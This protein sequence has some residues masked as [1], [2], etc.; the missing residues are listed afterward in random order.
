MASEPVPLVVEHAYPLRVGC[1]AQ[2]CAVAFLAVIGSAAAA[3][4]PAGVA[5]VQGGQVPLGVLLCVLSVVGLP[6]LIFAAIL[7][8]SGVR[9]VLNPPQLYVTADAL[10][11]PPQLRGATPDAQGNVPP[12]AP[13]PQPLVVP[14][15]AIRAVKGSDGRSTRI[16]IEHD[17]APT[18]LLLPEFLLTGGDFEGLEAV[19]RKAVPGAFTEG[20]PGPPA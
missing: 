19:L 2:G 7:V 16:R 6:A 9:E 12:N 10:V 20:A 15:A 4:L 18:P 13:G 3:T 1:A 5:M 17:L 8:V 11:L 14:F